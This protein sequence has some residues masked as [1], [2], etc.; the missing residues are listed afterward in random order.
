MWNFANLVCMVFISVMYYIVE[1]EFLFS[2]HSRQQ[3]EGENSCAD[4]NPPGRCF[5]TVVKFYF[6]ISTWCGLLLRC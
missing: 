2:F 3:D 1:I 5:P 4:P 6:C